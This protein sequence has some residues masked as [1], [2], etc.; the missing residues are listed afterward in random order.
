MSHLKNPG[1]RNIRFLLQILL[2]ILLTTAATVLANAEKLASADPIQGNYPR[3]FNQN[4]V[5]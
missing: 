4:L 3:H 5:W 1:R 2:I